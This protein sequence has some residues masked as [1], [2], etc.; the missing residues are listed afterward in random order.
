AKARHR[1]TQDIGVV[2]T[3]RNN[4]GAILR[5]LGEVKRRWKEYFDGLLN[6][7]FARQQLPVRGNCWPHQSLNRE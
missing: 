6:E 7:E 4:E 1:A 2:K 5:K 3:V